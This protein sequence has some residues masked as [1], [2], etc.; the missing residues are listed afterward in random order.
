MNLSRSPHNVDG[1]SAVASSA[2]VIYALV[3]LCWL[4]GVCLL[5]TAPAGATSSRIQ[6]MGGRGGYF[7]DDFNVLRWYGSLP[8]YGNQA[9]LELGRTN[10]AANDSLGI[11]HINGQAGG[12]HISFDSAGKWGTA[13]VYFRDE[14]A[15]GLTPG[16][17]FTGLYAIGRG[18]VAVGLYYRGTSFE[19]T[20]AP[21]DPVGMSTS[22][23]LNTWGLGIRIDIAA[24]V[25]C[26]VA[27]EIMNAD[28]QA[29]ETGDSAP[30][31]E[32]DGSDSWGARTRFFIRLSEKVACV[33]LFDYAKEVRSTFSPLLL[34]AADVDARLTRVGLGFN[35]LPDGD[36]L[37]VFDGEYRNGRR[38]L[39]GAGSA[40]ARYADSCRKFTSLH[41]RVGVES[42]LLAW[43]T[44]R[45][46]VE[47]RRTDAD[48]RLQPAPPGGDDQI[49]HEVHVDVPLNLGLGLHFGNFDADLVLNDRAPFSFGYL[50]TGTEQKETT[51][52]TA[53][54]LK[55]SW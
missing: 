33:P 2:R 49:S 16:G 41:A 30:L 27:G 17:A 43:L 5:D 26:D 19:R 3:G 42:R 53:I 23:Y 6:A 14:S 50:L 34:D 44:L 47:Y 25:Y 31:V 28:F 10:F 12:A 55:Y 4:A 32:N 8:E 18:P 21:S 45:A 13:A 22:E 46:G 7:E 9:V 37:L 48:Q 1:Q 15:G 40:A 36:N 11:D 39:A 29:T 38:H 52:F 54:T 51:T 20:A 35:F 24:G